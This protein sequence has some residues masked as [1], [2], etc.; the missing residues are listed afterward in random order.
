M[1]SGMR[2]RGVAVWLLMT[3]SLQAAT[4][5]IT[6][7][8]QRCSA[9]GSFGTF[10][11]TASFSDSDQSV[12]GPVQFRVGDADNHLDLI[13]S[14]TELSD[15]WHFSSN[16]DYLVGTLSSEST[17]QPLEESITLQYTCLGSIRIFDRTV[18]ELLLDVSG[19]QS[20]AIV[21]ALDPTHTY[22]IQLEMLW[23]ITDGPARDGRGLTQVLGFQFHTIPAPAAGL[24][25]AIGAGVVLSARS[26]R[27]SRHTNSRKEARVS[28]AIS[29]H[30][31]IPPLS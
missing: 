26:T 28:P 5:N 10:D 21:L 15:T 23:Q 4:A 30:A 16:M 31:V 9:T 12:A 6:L 18:S 25:V 11:G 2:M 19:S 27:H 8:D 13:A 20:G 24:L 3:G 14:P 17:F 7:I 22:G 29:R 1:K